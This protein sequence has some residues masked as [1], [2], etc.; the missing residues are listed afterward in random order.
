V[1]CTLKLIKSQRDFVWPTLTL[2]VADMLHDVIDFIRGWYRCNLVKH[3]SRCFTCY[4]TNQSQHWKHTAAWGIYWQ[5]R[6]NSRQFTK[7]LQLA[8]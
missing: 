1:G 5:Q 2:R 4:F 7:H 6:C 3:V 8:V